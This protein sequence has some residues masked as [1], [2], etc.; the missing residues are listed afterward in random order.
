MFL[1][2]QKELRHGIM[3]QDSEGND[4]GVSKKAGLQAVS[5]VAVSRVAVSAACLF[6]PASVMTLVERQKW[7]IS[8][9]RLRIPV[10]LCVIATS[11]MCALPFATAIY[12]QTAT[13]ETTALG[14]EFQRDK[15]GRKIDR[16]YFN[17]GL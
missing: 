10:N 1:M 7:Y 2:R 9:P 3:V 4:L 17:R 5:Q 11:M 14:P 6:I 13:L 8:N 16:V 12:P 15:N